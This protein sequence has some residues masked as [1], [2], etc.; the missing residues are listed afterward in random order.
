MF[1]DLNAKFQKI[2]LNSVIGRMRKIV[3]IH[4]LRNILEYFLLLD[5]ID[6]KPNSSIK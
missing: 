4:I 2:L 6:D 1:Y 3:G 5:I